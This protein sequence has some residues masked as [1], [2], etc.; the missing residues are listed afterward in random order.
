MLMDDAMIKSTQYLGLSLLLWGYSSIALAEDSLVDERVKGELATSEKPF[1]ITPHKANYLLPVT[2]QTRTNSLP[3][4]IKYPDEDFSIDNLEAKFQISFKFPIMYNVFGDNGHLFFAYTNQSYWQ[5]YNE[6]ASSPFRETNHEPEVFMLFNNDW[7]IAGFTN[8]FL[9]VG[10]VHQSNGQTNQL[11]RSWNRI[12][13][14][15]IF[16]RGPF[17]LGLRV[18]WR[19]PEDAKED[20]N[21]AKGDDNPDIG[22]YMGN[23]ELTGVYGLDEHRFT[24]LLRNNLRDNNRGAVELTWSYPIIGTLRVY[25]QYFNGYGE[26]LIDYNHHNQRI[27]IGIALNDLL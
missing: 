15:A 4:E 26:S 9:G 10:A 11:S 14:S 19:I 8:S 12:Y 17:A 21:S 13:G 22:S 18:W 23:F 16:D 7:K 2:Y 27:G 3:F 1:V 25:T 6:E 24:M 5:V 20:I